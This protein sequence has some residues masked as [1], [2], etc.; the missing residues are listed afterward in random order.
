MPQCVVMIMPF[1]QQ[2]VAEIERIVTSNYSI[3]TIGMTEDPA[4]CRMEHSNP[5]IWYEWAVTPAASAENIER[6]F[7]SKGMGVGSSAVGG[8]SYIYIFIASKLRD[9]NQ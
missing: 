2:I 7:V 8:A 4:S 9:M 3:W 5:D 6:Y 1:E